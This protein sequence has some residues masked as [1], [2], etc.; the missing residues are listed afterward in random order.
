MQRKNYLLAFICLFAVTV[1]CGDGKE[2]VSDSSAAVKTEPAQQAVEAEEPFDLMSFSA[3]DTSSGVFFGEYD[4]K[5]DDEITVK[6]GLEVTLQEGRITDITLLD[7]TWV[8]PAAAQ[9]IPQR[10]I[11]QQKLPVDAVSGASVASW[12]IMTATAVALEIDLMVLED[13]GAESDTTDI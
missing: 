9:Q 11:E 2:K 12:S 13:L 3:L 4:E 7:T 1:A 6:V 5:V 8:H 10:I